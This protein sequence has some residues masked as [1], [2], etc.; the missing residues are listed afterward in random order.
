VPVGQQ[1][2]VIG[3]GRGITFPNDAYLAF[4]QAMQKCA[5]IAAGLRPVLRMGEK[6][7]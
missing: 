6:L 4:H 3:A 1:R 2:F 5:D 7:E